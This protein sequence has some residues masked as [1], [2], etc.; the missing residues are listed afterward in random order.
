MLGGT[1][2]NTN[3]PTRR[4][5]PGHVSMGPMRLRCT[6]LGVAIFAFGLLIWSRLLLVTN[7]PKTAIAEPAAAERVAANPGG[8]DRETA[9]PDPRR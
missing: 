9:R 7:Y 2:V 1:Y 4:G 8:S 3:D 5:E 6:L